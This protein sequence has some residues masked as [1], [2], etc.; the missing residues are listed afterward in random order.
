MKRRFADAQLIPTIEYAG[1]PGRETHRVVDHGTIH[2]AEIL[3]QK[4]FAFEP[5]AR[6]A[7]RNLCLGIKS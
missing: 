3:D 6:V 7:S 1:L 2:R 4:C 5:D